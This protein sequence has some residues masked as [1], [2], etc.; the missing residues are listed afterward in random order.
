MLPYFSD[1]MRA[2]SQ[3]A[4]QSLTPVDFCGLL[5]RCGNDFAAFAPPLT[6]TEDEIDQMA[7]LLG[8]SIAAASASLS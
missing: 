3:T 4:A 5:L 6:V 7:S 2:I 8:E 1:V